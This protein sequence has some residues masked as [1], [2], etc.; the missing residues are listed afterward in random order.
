MN[1]I[2]ALV[3]GF[4]L[5]VGRPLWPAAAQLS[6]RVD[7]VTVASGGLSLSG[8][9]WRPAGSGPFPAVLFNHGSYG[10][11]NQT[12]MDEPAVLGRVFVQHGYAFLFLFRQGIGLSRGQGT[13]DGDLMARA[14]A[15]MGVAGRNRIQLQLLENEEL[16]EA[17]SGLAFLR[18]LGDVDSQRMVVAGHSFGGSITLL[19]AARDPTIRAAV[20]FA[21][22]A[23][24]WGQSP[25][26]R[27]RLLAAVDRTVAPV[28]FIYAAN[29][30][31]VTPGEALAAEMRRL[32]KS[33]AL[34]I[35]PALGATARDGHNLIYRSVPTWEPDVFRF[36]DGH[37]R[38]SARAP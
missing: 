3:L 4:A 2:A 36:L 1:R 20:A 30:Y 27:A 12:V 13:A 15:A 7:T 22:A 16:T 10:G 6:A 14:S 32:G 33:P 38:R 26:L 24:S 29:D 9:L 31:S 11:A 37:L 17:I 5:V 18:T 25:Q 23:L 19:L 34:K 35:Y 28:L 21:P 8:L